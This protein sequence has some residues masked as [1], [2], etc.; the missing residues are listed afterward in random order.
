MS[1]IFISGVAGFLGSHLADAFIADGHTVVGIDNMSGGERDNVPA[2]CIFHE[3][4]CNDT[5]AVR[6]CMAECE[7]VYHCAA[8]AY[9]GLSV[10]SPHLVTQSIVTASTRSPLP[11][12]LARAASSCARRW[13]GTGR[14]PRRSPKTWP[15]CRRT[16]T[17]SARSPPRCCS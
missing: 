4:D 12:R 17:A 15:R 7:V 6:R 1:R 5:A 9:E 8:R 14:T 2:G 13:H 11:S 10:F 16:R 3:V